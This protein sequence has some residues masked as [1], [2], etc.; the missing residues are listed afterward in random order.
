MNPGLKGYSLAIL[1]E[2]A[3][4]MNPF[5]ALPCYQGGMNPD[6]VLLFRYAL[7]IPLMGIILKAR[8]LSLKISLREACVLAV[9]GLLMAFSSLTLFFSYNYMAAGIAST[10]LFIY[11]ALVA[12][13]M[14]LIFHERM[15]VVTVV[16]MILAL[17]GIG[18]LYENEDGS[19]LSLI[20]TVIV[21]LSSLSY[22]IYLV[23]VDKT[24]L[25][26]MPALKVTFYI[27]LFGVLLFVGRIV[28]G[29]ELTVPTAENL[30]LWGDLIGLAAIPTAFSFLCTTAA[31]KYIGPTPTAILGAFEPLTAIVF[32]V[33]V[34]G[35]I[36][37]GRDVVGIILI[38]MA[39]T[40]VVT[41]SDITK[42]L[43]R[44][45]KLFYGAK[46]HPNA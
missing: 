42:L 17:A 40:M 30:W 18:L 12:L 1:A 4:G 34:F 6:S 35:E 26:G 10:L 32:G 41:S 25:G 8:G 38:I 7:A 14:G 3:Y 19:T 22:A 20:G 21:F 16:S 36:L 31:I 28:L 37:T 46:H 9:F 29:A 24:D 5:F 23:A 33:T 44:L 2:V 11:P 39:V 43:L 27:L 13:I 15:N 45:R